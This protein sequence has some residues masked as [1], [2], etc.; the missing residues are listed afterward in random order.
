MLTSNQ[1]ANQ[2]IVRFDREKGDIISN[3]KLQKLLYY[4]QGWNLALNGERLFDA[5]IEG[6]KVGPV[7]EEQYHQFKDF[8]H[9]AICLEGKIEY[10]KNLILDT[11][12]EVY[13][14]I[15]ARNLVDMT[16]NE[17]PWRETGQS[18]V[19][20]EESLKEF[21]IGL[22]SENY[23]IHAKFL[24]LWI[25]KSLIEE[26]VSTLGL[27]IQRI[28]ELGV[29]SYISDPMIEEDIPWKGFS[30]FR[31]KVSHCYSQY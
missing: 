22:L 13:G 26:D 30:Y 19:I 7:V 20:S 14:G 12:I 1:V 6:W 24:D 5:N 31:R 3:L 2:I 29:I 4:A 15:S 25:S 11:V 23:S 8:Q 27:L 21:F 18:K 28:S 9:D 17:S 10:E 16:H